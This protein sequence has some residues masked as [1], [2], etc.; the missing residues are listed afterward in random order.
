MRSSKMRVENLYKFMN[1]LFAVNVE[2]LGVIVVVD[3][4]E[5]TVA[6]FDERKLFG[7]FYKNKLI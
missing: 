3:I 7:K 4:L 5:V 1:K 6:R 2:L